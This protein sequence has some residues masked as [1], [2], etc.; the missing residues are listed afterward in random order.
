MTEKPKISKSDDNKKI[1][2]TRKQATRTLPN[3]RKS[4]RTFDNQ[5]ETLDG[6]GLSAA[7]R[8]AITEARKIVI[9]ELQNKPLQELYHEAERYNIDGSD[10]SKQELI[11]AVAQA[12]SDEEGRYFVEGVLEIVRTKDKDPFGFLRLVNYGPS[13]EDL[14]VSYS[15]LRLGLRQGD[16]VAGIARPAKKGDKSGALLWIDTVNGKRPEE[17]RHR[18]PFNGLTAI[19]PDKLIKLTTTQARLSTRVIDLFA[20]IGFGQRSLVVAPPK[21]GKTTL[22]KEIAQGITKNYPETK[23]I[24][25]LID[26]RPEEVTELERTINGEVVYSTFDQRPENHV[27]VADFV[28]ERAKRLVE[29]KE[30]VVILMDSITRLARAANLTERPSGRTL[31]GGVDP[32][33]L[34]KPKRFFGAARNVEE[35]G[36]LTIIATALVDTGSRMDDV[37]FEEFKGTGNQE[38]KLDRELAERRIF[39]AIDLKVSGTRKEELLLSSPTLKAI[40]QLRDTLGKSYDKREG[41]FNRNIDLTQNTR[42]VLAMLKKSKTNAKF[43][44]NILE[45]HFSQQSK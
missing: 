33:A 35:G 30:D 10:M 45:S 31:S 13:R 6:V 28:L 43:R 2:Q 37:I 12:Q 18:P 11:I 42:K 8:K 32:A 29:E 4:I 24:M 5:G 15:Q 22:L 16:L 3:K 1:N 34:Y 19:Y 20:P 44:Q 21:A 25:L 23:L 41:S 27:R 26:E 36:S 38:I 39:P 7:E 14:Y 40:W 17:A 9:A